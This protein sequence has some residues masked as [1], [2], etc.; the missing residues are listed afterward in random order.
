[1]LISD[2]YDKR[3]KITEIAI[4]TSR[5]PHNKKTKLKKC[6]TVHQAQKHPQNLRREYLPYR[7]IKRVVKI[8]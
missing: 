2:S 5:F 3:A 6:T 8:C 7:A 1:M 4:K